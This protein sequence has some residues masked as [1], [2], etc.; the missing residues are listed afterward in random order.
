MATWE[1]P[2]RKRGGFHRVSIRA[3]VSSS[4][5]SSTSRSH[6]GTSS[7]MCSR[8]LASAV[9]RSGRAQS[10]SLRYQAR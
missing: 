8:S 6:V 2:G 3:A 9:A 10:P 1:Q 7:G 4:P 5:V